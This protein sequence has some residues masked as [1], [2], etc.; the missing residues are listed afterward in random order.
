VIFD[1]LYK[2]WKLNDLNYCLFQIIPR[3]AVKDD[4]ILTSCLLWLSSAL[5]TS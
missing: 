4:L 5:N 1:S 3:D 2:D